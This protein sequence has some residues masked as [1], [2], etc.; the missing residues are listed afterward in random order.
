MVNMSSTYFTNPSPTM[1]AMMID[2]Q[3]PSSPYPSPSF[4]VSSLF[5]PHSINFAIV[6]ASIFSTDPPPLSSFSCTGH[7]FRSL[8]HFLHPS[9]NSPDIRDSSELG[10]QNYT[11]SLPDQSLCPI[12]LLIDIF[13]FHLECCSLRGRTFSYLINLK[14]ELLPEVRLLDLPPPLFNIYRIACLISLAIEQ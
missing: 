6:F 2:F 9:T 4:P 3:P 10:F 14:I 7:Y 12:S 5:R 11:S 1:P 13:C 8:L